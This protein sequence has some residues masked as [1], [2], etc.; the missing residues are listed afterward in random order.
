MRLLRLSSKPD[1]RDPLLLGIAD[2]IDADINGGLRDSDESDMLLISNL[3]KVAGEKA[4]KNSDFGRA[5]GYLQTALSLLPQDHW[6]THHKFSIELHLA[7]AQCAHAASN[8]DLAKESLREI[9]SHGRELDDTLDAH[10]K[11]IFII[12]LVRGKQVMALKSCVEI[13]GQLGE[14]VDSSG[15]NIANMVGSI[16]H[17]INSRSDAELFNFKQLGASDSNL[18]RRLQ[19]LCQ[20]C[21]ISS[22]GVDPKTNMY[23]LCRSVEISLCEGYSQVRGS[24]LVLSP[25][26]L[27]CASTHMWCIKDT[28]FAFVA[29]GLFLCG[30]QKLLAEGK[31][32]AMIAMRLFL[33][34]FNDPSQSSKLSLIYYG[35]FAFYVLP[36][37]SCAEKLREASITSLGFGDVTMAISTSQ[38]A[39]QVIATNLYHCPLYLFD[40]FS[41]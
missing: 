11:L 22:T 32:L 27:D 8:L 21:L 12:N 19:F 15:N 2:C 5:M 16:R 34:R 28:P 6:D 40:P 9:I 24:S 7:L 35:F 26:L 3:N 39:V 33:E 1:S 31:R 38:Q 10:F 37:R 20:A 29:F 13:L 17:T 23:V 25:K 36:L 18:S 4:A 41:F 14:H 30:R